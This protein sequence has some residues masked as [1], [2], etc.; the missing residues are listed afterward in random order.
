MW[1]VRI[2]TDDGKD[3][4]GNPIHRR[5]DN[6][7]SASASKQI[8]SFRGTVAIEDFGKVANAIAE[9]VSD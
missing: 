3:E 6:P 8:I 9:S 5:H 1:I 4:H 7:S 2:T